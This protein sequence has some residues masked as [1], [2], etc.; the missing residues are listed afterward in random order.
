LIAAQLPRRHGLAT[1]KRLTH[2]NH[3]ANTRTSARGVISAIH[4]QY[5]GPQ[6]NR[7]KT[8]PIFSCTPHS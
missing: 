5:A 7:K 8:Q 2:V 6:E 1:D 3:V 4:R